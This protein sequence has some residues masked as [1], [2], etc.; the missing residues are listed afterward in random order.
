MARAELLLFFC[1]F[2]LPFLRS[3]SKMILE[4]DMRRGQKF[5][6]VHTDTTQKGSAS[7]ENQ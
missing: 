5:P 6:Y 7:H 3:S 1:N 2:S 4:S